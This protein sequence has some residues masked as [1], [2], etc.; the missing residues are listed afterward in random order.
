MAGI[1]SVSV[2]YSSIQE[3]ETELRTRQAGESHI[4]GRSLTDEV[5]ETT[6]LYN[7]TSR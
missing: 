3:L 7:V 2:K 6:M 1:S 5:T 4:A